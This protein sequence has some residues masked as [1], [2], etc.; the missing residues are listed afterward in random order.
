MSASSGRWPKRGGDAPRAWNSC[1]LRA[2]VGDVV[3]AA[4]DVGDGEFDVVDDRG[5]RVEIAAVGAHQDGVA[6][7]GLVD[8]LGPAH[9]IVPAHV[10][11]FQQEAPMRACARGLQSRALGVRQRERGAVVDR[12]QVALQLALALELQLLRRFVAGI[13]PAGGLQ[14][15]DG[16]VV[17]GEAIG[18][19]RPSPAIPGRASA[20][21]PR[22]RRR[23]PRSSGRGRCRRGAARRRRP[24]GARTASWRG[25]CRC[26]RHAAGP[27]GSA[28]SGR[29]RPCLSRRGRRW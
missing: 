9:E 1:D 7:A 2:G 10:L 5:Q 3:G 22:C 23:T 6:L 18:L 19:A 17:G 24:A 16:R 26:C 15:R 20:G 11:M 8:M 28:R 13:E 12:R 25:R 21:R 27:S 4:D 14:L 29:A